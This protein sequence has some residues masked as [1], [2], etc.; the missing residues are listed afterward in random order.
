MQIKI[1]FLG[2]SAGVPTEKRNH[3]S[4]LLIYNGEYLLFDCGE[5]TQRQLRKAGI[6]PSKINKIFITHMHADHILGLAGIL[7]TLAMND[8]NKKL[9]IYGPKGIKEYLKFLSKF[10]PIINEI[11]LEV[12][13]LVKNKEK[14]VFDNYEIIAMKLKHI[15]E[16]YG[17]RFNEKEKIKIK[18]EYINFVGGPSPIFKKLKEGKSIK[19]KN[20][21]L[22]P[23]EATYRIKGRSIAFI[24]DTTKCKNAIELAKDTDL[25][26]I[27]CVYGK[28][29]EERAKDYMHLSTKDV[30]EIISLSNPKK[31]YLTHISERYKDKEKNLIKEVQE[32]IRKKDK[33]IKKE[34]I[35]KEKIKV[36]LA[37]DLNEVNI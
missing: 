16:V 2:T 37:W 17:Y 26:I 33:K 11:N 3:S 36:F 8:Y 25:L 19:I 12:K 28:E 14:F 35:K 24:L 13:E 23:E 6:S 29:N 1:I 7:Q 30:G 34:K 18:K 9:E 20:K 22:T 5:G 32:E 15:V 4:F 10:F 21:I 31:V 27:E